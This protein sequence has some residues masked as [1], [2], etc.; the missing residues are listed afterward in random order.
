MAYEFDRQGVLFAVGLADAGDFRYY[1]APFFH[2]KHIMFVDVEV[3]DY[4][5][6]MERCAFHYSARQQHRLKIRHRGD[7]AHSPHFERYEAQARQCA[8][9]GEIYML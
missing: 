1:L 5:F 2:I 9:G 4:I 6:V 3:L 7:N 8:L